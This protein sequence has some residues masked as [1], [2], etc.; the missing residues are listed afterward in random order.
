MIGGLAGG[1]AFIQV[2]IYGAHLGFDETSFIRSLLATCDDSFYC[3]LFPSC[4][5]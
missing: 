3:R 2:R 5:P 4:W 1:F